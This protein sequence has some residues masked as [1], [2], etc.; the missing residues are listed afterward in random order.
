[1][2]TGLIYDPI[3]L[4]HDM[5]SHPE[6]SRRL[7]ETISLLKESQLLDKLTSISPRAATIGELALVHS[8]YHINRVESASAGGGKWLDGDTFSSSD[9]FNVALYAAGGTLRGIDAV[10]SGEVNNVFALVRPPGHHATQQEAMGFCLFNNI[11]IAA[12]Y[13]QKNHGIDR[14]LIVD[15]DVHHG[16]G[17]EDIFYNDPSILYFSTHQHPH[18]PGTGAIDDD[19]ADE[20]KGTTVNVPLPAYCGDAEYQRA[21]E[22]ILIPVAHRFKPQLIL[23]SAGYDNHWADPLSGM[24]LTVDGFANI[25]STIKRLADELC[26]GR[27]L[28]T[29]EGGYHLKALSNSIK[30][31][32]E[33]LSDIPRSEDPLGKPQSNYMPRD[34]DNII[35]M[36]ATKHGLK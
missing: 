1:M 33:V 34:I 13:A 19:G 4:K 23:V 10:I 17:T 16:N 3:Y 30:A 20:G 21:Y 25:V 29:L 27:L 7:E 24:Q 31:T 11:A 9:S 22:E 8:E 26:E 2:K 14:V 36:V 18:Y 35:D 15:F 5:G 32:F 28:L 6:N 12:K